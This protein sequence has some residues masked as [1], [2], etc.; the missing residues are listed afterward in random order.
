[1]KDL[2]PGADLSV[3]DDVWPNSLH[4]FLTFFE[5]PWII[6][7]SKE[8]TQVTK[9]YVYTVNRNRPTVQQSRKKA[10]ELWKSSH[11]DFV[12]KLVF[13][14]KPNSSPQKISLWGERKSSFETSLKSQNELDTSE[15]LNGLMTGRVLQET[16]G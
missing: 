15:R 12:D 1:M 6:G 11:Y 14:G 13:I 4:C 2:F 16:F 3:S 8:Q 5:R 9:F 7:Q 10:R